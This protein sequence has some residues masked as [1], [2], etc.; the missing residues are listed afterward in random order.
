[1]IAFIVVYTH[2]ESV[3]PVL[4][5]LYKVDVI[6]KVTKCKPYKKY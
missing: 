2:K 4:V 3:K 6:G 5:V 1:M